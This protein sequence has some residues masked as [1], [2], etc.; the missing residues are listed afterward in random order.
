MPVALL[1][2]VKA[3]VQAGAAVSSWLTVA[4]GGRSGEGRGLILA[5]EAEVEP[6]QH[7]SP[8]LGFMRAPCRGMA[9]AWQVIPHGR[10]I[11]EGPEHPGRG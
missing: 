9:G 8:H 3:V 5:V 7:S 2:G 1:A 6:V 4:D 10:G 11:G